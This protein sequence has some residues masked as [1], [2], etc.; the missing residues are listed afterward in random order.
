MASRETQVQ[1]ELKAAEI[2]LQGLPIFFKKKLVQFVKKIVK[3]AFFSR[4]ILI[5]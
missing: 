2:H 5:T 3:F 1:N 4:K